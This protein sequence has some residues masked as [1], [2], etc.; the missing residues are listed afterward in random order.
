[1]GLTS[2]ITRKNLEKFLRRYATNKRTLDIGSG[3]S[4]Y[5]RFFPNRLTVDIDSERKPEIVADAHSMPFS[6]EEFEVV[7]CTEV[8]EHVLDPFKVEK[9][10]RRVTKQGGI[11]ILSTRFVFPLHDTPHDYWRFT[12]YGLKEIFKEWEIVELV[13]ETHNFSTIGALLQ[14]ISFQSELRL[15]K[16]SKLTILILGWIFDHLN[17][18]TKKEYGDIKHKNEEED[19]MPT[20]YYI[21]CKKK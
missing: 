8:L 16:I 1:M 4:S 15:N 13:G 5:E 14:R 2:K 11:L 3:G 21:V 12:K 18:L 6:D 9:E 20:G 17:W 19:I 10:I 7:L